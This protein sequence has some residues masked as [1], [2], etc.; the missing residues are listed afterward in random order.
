VTSLIT[1]ESRVI[2]VVPDDI[3]DECDAPVISWLRVFRNLQVLKL[4]RFVCAFFC[5]IGVQLVF[6]TRRR[7]RGAGL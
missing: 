2:D 1:A 6:L 7:V 3:T 4:R 5:F